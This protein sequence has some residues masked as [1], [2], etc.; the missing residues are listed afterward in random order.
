MTSDRWA[1]LLI[2][3]GTLVGTIACTRADIYAVTEVAPV[4]QDSGTPAAACASNA[5][6]AGDTSVTLQVGSASRSYVLHV[7]STYD[8]TKPAPLI[9]DFHGIGGTGWGQLSSS[10][11]PAVTD[12]DGVVMAFPDGKSGPIGTGWNMGPCCV[13]NVDDLGF[14]KAMVNDIRRVACIDFT[15]IYAIGV[16]TGGGMVNYLA[17]AAADLF[18][19]VS[20]AAF[21]LLEETA[22]NCKPTRPISV[23]SFRGTADTHVPYAGGPSTLVPGMPIT[24]LGAQASFDKW[25]QIDGCTGTR[26]PE[27]SNGCASYSGCA[28][29]VEVILCTKQGG[30]EQPGDAV[31]GWPALKRHAL[32]AP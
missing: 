12:P 8:A 29:G 31:I 24:F 26:S 25:A 14:A 11:Y 15:R 5:L 1:I 32:A 22:D 2:A 13:A 19:A 21:D 10:P 27:D 20:P 28:D 7:P 23:I 3:L 16:L 4:A 18:A 30:L 17:C 9:L 6:P